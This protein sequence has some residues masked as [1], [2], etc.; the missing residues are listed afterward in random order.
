MVPVLTLITSTVGHA[1][2]IM[3]MELW[4]HVYEYAR[5]LYIPV[6]IVW[7]EEIWL[8]S[9]FAIDGHV[10]VCMCMENFHDR[11]ILLD[12]AWLPNSL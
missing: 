9:S 5:I 1:F 6:L 12:L 4:L 11:L 3:C 7:Q 2:R 10:V 8:A